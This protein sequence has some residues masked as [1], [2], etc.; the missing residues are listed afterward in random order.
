MMDELKS[1]QRERREKIL[2]IAIADS[3]SPSRLSLCLVAVLELYFL[4]TWLIFNRSFT[5]F[6]VY[7]YFICYSV[8]LCFSVLAFALSYLF[9]KDKKNGYKKLTALQAIFAFMI[10]LWAVLITI[11]DAD[12][13]SSVNYIIYATIVVILPAVI[14]IDRL[15]MNLMY[16]VCD[17]ILIVFTLIDRP[18]NMFGS[19]VNFSVFAIV[20]LCAVNI[21]KNT[22]DLSILREIEL[23]DQADR[24]HLT[25]LY[26]RQR[27]NAISRNIIQNNLLAKTELSC[28]MA[29]LDDFKQINDKY[30]HLMGD[31]VLQYVSGIV[32][33]VVRQ[34]DGMTFRYGGEEFLILFSDCSSRQALNVI[35]KIQAL[36]SEGMPDLPEKI[37]LSFGIYTAVPT[38]EDN[39]EQFYSAADN[40][41][42][43]SKNNG[44]DCCTA[45]EETINLG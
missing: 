30:G 12:H 21:Y 40:L 27:L 15:L 28:V 24:D 44:K 34:N 19:V 9:E 18:E 16:L 10:L 36:L 42:Y 39:I 11:F 4:I 26:N 13:H 25:G 5:D 3:L 20:S 14:Y 7:R 2:R 33:E 1:S 37:S 31:K 35:E 32:R 23:Q 22:K 38:A 43:T 45:F 29:D 6:H 17:V 8:L 41:M